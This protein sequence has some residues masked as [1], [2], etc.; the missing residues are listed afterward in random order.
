MVRF[1]LPISRSLFLTV[2]FRLLTVLMY[3]A[4][5]LASFFVADLRFR[6]LVLGLIFLRWGFIPNRII[7]VC[8]FEIILSGSKT[9]VFIEFSRALIVSSP[10]IFL[11]L[12]ISWIF[13]KISLASWISS[14]VNFLLLFLMLEPPFKEFRKIV[15]VRKTFLKNHQSIKRNFNIF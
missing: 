3:L 2:S 1:F 13:S 11:K 4:S 6:R 9:P 14:A 12:G 10:N 8:I 7:K 5:F 15:K